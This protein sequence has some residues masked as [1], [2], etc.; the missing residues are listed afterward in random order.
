MKSQ[1]KFSRTELLIGSEGLE[2]L[3]KSKVAV[4]GIGGV[5]SYTVE[6]LARGGIGNLILV[7]DDN[8]CLTNLNRQIHALFSTIS[9]S[10]VDVMENRIHDINPECNVITHK[11]FV[12]EANTAE[13]IDPDTDYV[14]DAIDTVSSKI[15]LVVWCKEH[16][17]KIISC[18]GTG[19]KFDPTRFKI[20]DI[21]DTKICP[22]AKVMRYELRRRGIES[23]KVLYSDE[24]PVKPR[25]GVITCKEGCVCSGT[26]GS[27]KCTMKRQIVGSISYVP[28]AAGLIIGGEVIN[29]LLGIK[30]QK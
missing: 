8:V 12:K 3:Q 25:E 18:M 14:V 26:G 16:N 13:L 24:P 19:N 10:K 22:L 2:K 27:K 7:D 5:G 30:K 23:L 11:T 4:F 6:A 1:H 20:A 17:I 21:Y 15:S 28:S 9:K 29:D